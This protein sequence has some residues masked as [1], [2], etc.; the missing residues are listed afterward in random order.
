MS[1]SGQIL[2]FG[3]GCTIYVGEDYLTITFFGQLIARGATE[4]PVT[5]VSAKVNSKPWDWDRI[6]CRSKNRSVFEHCIIKNSNY[7]IFIENGSADILNCRFERNSL[8]GIVVK[9]SEVLIDR[10]VFTGGHVLAV[11]LQPGARVRADSL[12][13][14]KTS[15]ALPARINH[16]WFL[17]TVQFP[18]TP[19]A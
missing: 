12:I 16:P 9:N 4:Q 8:C 14:E 2:E 19:M 6:Y 10:S 11:N 17:K 3:P 7:G 18:V 13:I 1:P 5:I 15:L